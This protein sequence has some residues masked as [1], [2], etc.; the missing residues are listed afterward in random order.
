MKKHYIHLAA[1]S[2]FVVFKAEAQLFTRIT[3]GPVVT[4]SGDSRSVNFVDVNHDGWED[5]FI[6]NGPEGGGKN[7]LYL[8]NG[9]GNFTAV[10]GDDLVTSVGSYDGA[11]F[12]DY[13]N[14]GDADAFV[15]TWYNEKNHFFRNNGDG[16]FTEEPTALPATIA[17]YSETAAWGD[18]DNDG[19]AD[20]YVSNSSGNFKNL[21]YKNNGDGTFTKINTGPAVTDTRASR[22]VTWADYDNDGDADLYVTNESNEPNN[23]YQNAGDGTFISITGGPLVSDTRSTMSASWGDIDNDGDLD[24]FTA[25]SGYFTSQ[26]NQLFLNN[27]DGTFT[28]IT[29]GDV[30]DDSGT[31][32]SSA[33]ADY[34]NDGDLDL[35]VSNGFF[36]GSVVNRLYQNDGAG[37]FTRDL[38]SATDLSTPCSFGCAWGDVN[39]DGFPELVFATCN[40]SGSGTHPSDILYLNNGNGNHWL[41]FHLKGT[42]SNHSALGA[43]VYVKASINGNSTWQMREV[44]SQSGYCSQNSM[45]AS[46]GLG[47][48]TAADSVRIHFP[49]GFDTV[50]VNVT[51]NQLHTIE[52]T[53]VTGIEEFNNRG[54][55]ELDCYPNPAEGNFYVLIPGKPQQPVTMK[56]LNASGLVVEEKQHRVQEG[57]SVFYWERNRQHMPGGIYF[58]ELVGENWLGRARISLH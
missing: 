52:E 2:L 9:D 11:T 58:L 44:T 38:T 54:F 32:F 33:F 18:Y 42:Q 3:T 41:A 49:S 1:L 16:T 25:N 36:S 53:S 27:G 29:E 37:N 50:L 30:V 26:K 43:R 17:S 34:D 46:F 55:I 7:F 8:N 10:S 21:L 6:S 56:L 51:G 57:A 48:A 15:V 22:G 19:N 35:A 23:L 40:N 28:E 47:N 4:T 13:D 5:L 39:N 45:R 20:L 24:L 12:S 14:D 31:S